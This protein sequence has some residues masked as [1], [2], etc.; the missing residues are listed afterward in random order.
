MQKRHIMLAIPAYTGV[1]YLTT[2]RSIIADLLS[3]MRADVLV[4]IEDETGG[5]DV[6]DV[7]AEIV[8]K[9]LASK[10]THLMMV[11]WDVC[12]QAG[13]IL[14]L[15]NHDYDL[16]GGIYP[17]RKDPIHF[18]VPPGSENEFPI[19]QRTNCLEISGLHGGFMLIK[20]EVLEKM[21]GHYQTLYFERQG[22]MLCGLFE[23]YWHGTSKLGED[24]A[25]CQRWRDIGGK[26][27]LDP[28]IQMG[29]VGTKVFA[30]QFGLWRDMIGTMQE[31]AE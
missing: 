19:D 26:V 3:L 8:A 11:D 5:G 2:M 21:T 27:W 10:C 15:L 24:Y 29:H 17:D 31:A 14:R 23:A 20:R 22:R 25:F 28:S 30:G 18:T 7:R 6:R 4:T 1:V 13:A 16:C 9:F 12:W